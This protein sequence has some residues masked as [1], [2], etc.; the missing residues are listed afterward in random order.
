MTIDR[1]RPTHPVQGVIFDMDGLML[2]TETVS[3]RAWLAAS[4]ELGHTLPASLW[5]DIIG[6]NH[7]GSQA[8]LRAQLGDDFPLQALTARTQ[9]H[10]Q[11]IL[12]SEGVQLKAGLLD[13]LDWIA[14]RA[15]PC[16]VATSTRHAL[17][18]KKLSAAGIL[19]RFQQVIGGDQVAHGKPAPDIYLKA[20]ADLRLAP[21]ACIALEDSV[22]GVRASHAA[23]VAVILVPDLVMPPASVQAL[24]CATVDSLTQAAAIIEAR[25]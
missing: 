5:H 14:A 2:D 13:L 7:A 4:T 10:Y 18:L 12:S 23:G 11:S 25:L 3:L 19:E 16:A 17:A 9:H 8:Y 1:S 22:N 6:M 20:A 21:S 24:A 15:L